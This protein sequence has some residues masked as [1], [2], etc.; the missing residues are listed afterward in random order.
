MIIGRGD[1]LLWGTPIGT[2]SGTIITADEFNISD[3]LLKRR[4]RRAQA[5]NVIPLTKNSDVLVTLVN[6]KYQTIIVL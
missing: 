3:R 2:G 1:I 5:V 4:D 6:C